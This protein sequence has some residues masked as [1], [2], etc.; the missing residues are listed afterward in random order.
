MAT[1]ALLTLLLIQPNDFE[2]VNK[3]LPNE[4]LEY[5]KLTLF[6]WLVRRK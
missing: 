4:T 3:Q 6:C 1:K 2:V 5:K